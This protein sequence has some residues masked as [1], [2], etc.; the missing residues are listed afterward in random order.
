M[1]ETNTLRKHPR[2]NFTTLQNSTLRDRRLSWKARGLFAFLWSHSQDFKFSVEWLTSNAKDGRDS[3]KAAMNE[4]Q[5][6][7]YLTITRVRGPDGRYVR[8]DW[9]LVDDPPTVQSRSES[10]RTENP[11]VDHKRENHP[12]GNGL[13]VIPSSTTEELCIRNTTCTESSHDAVTPRLT[14]PLGLDSESK[15]IAL[16][17]IAGRIQDNTLA[18]QI[19]DE[20]D[21]QLERKKIKG[22]WK[23]YLE[24]LI[25]RAKGGKFVPA[26]GKQVANRRAATAAGR[27]NSRKSTIATQESVQVHLERIQEA[28]RGGKEVPGGTSA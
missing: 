10:P 5:R 16:S 28:L 21:A 22:P 9:H 3:T 19:L 6:H 26:A 20:L 1:G 18:Q 2:S 17:V 13:P 14:P 15:R 24:G 23:A 8:I 12:R 27:A 7:G 4:L 25:R 11:F